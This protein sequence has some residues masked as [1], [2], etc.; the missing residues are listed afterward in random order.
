MQQ[1]CR[2]RYQQP[3]HRHHNTQQGLTVPQTA[4][5]Q[6]LQGAVLQSWMS[7][8]MLRMLQNRGVFTATMTSTT[9]ASTSQHTT[10]PH[11]SPDGHGPGPARGG[12]AVLDVGGHAEDAAEPWRFYSD[13]DVNNHSIDI[14]THKD[15]PFPRRPRSRTCKG[16]CCSPG[17]RRAC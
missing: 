12:V 16:R 3:Q 10:R 13:N 6:D 8:G 1:N 17:W 4:T 7:E 9:T 2:R 14:T 5:V 15:S 11:R